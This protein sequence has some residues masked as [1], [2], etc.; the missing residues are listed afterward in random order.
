[1]AEQALSTLPREAKGPLAAAPALNEPL[2]AV[3]KA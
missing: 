1:M 3:A 2:Q